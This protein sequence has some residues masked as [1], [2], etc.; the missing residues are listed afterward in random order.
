M[1]VAKAEKLILAALPARLGEAVLAQA[2]H[3][4]RRSLRRAFFDE[5]GTAPYAALRNRR[6]EEVKHRLEA[7]VTSLPSEIARACGFGHYA[8]FRRDFVSLFELEPDQCRNER[9][10]RAKLV[11]VAGRKRRQWP[12]HERDRER[13]PLIDFATGA[14]T[15]RLSYRAR[16]PLGGV[17]LSRCTFHPNPGVR[18][19][20]W[21]SATLTALAP[22]HSCHTLFL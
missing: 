15:P 3:V 17:T 21:A 14:P 19:R 5:R 11:A 8:R 16:L 13:A 9:P 1:L 10:A 7:D 6:F 2:L 18:G 20:C 12:G 22:L 4:G